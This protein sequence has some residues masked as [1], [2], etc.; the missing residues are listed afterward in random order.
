MLSSKK[1]KSSMD[2]KHILDAIR[3]SSEKDIN[4]YIANNG[5]VDAVIDGLSL[6]HHAVVEGQLQSV[7]TLLAHNADV[8]KKGKNGA[9]PLH[10]AAEKNE[11]SIM[12]VLIKRGAKFNVRDDLGNTPLH[13]AVASNAPD[14][15]R[16]CLQNHAD[17][18]ARNQRNCTPIHTAINYEKSI[19]EDGRFFY[20][21][22]DPEILIAL[23]E[24][25]NVNLNAK[26]Y[27]SGSSKTGRS[28][29]DY[30]AVH[31]N[32]Y[33]AF[34]IVEK[35][36]QSIAPEAD[37]LKKISELELKQSQLQ[38]EVNQLKTQIK[39]SSVTMDKAINTS[40]TM[41]HKSI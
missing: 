5:D 33:V 40:P 3:K 30:A 18:N 6:L 4:E 41:F 15:V 25:K 9:T 16:Y 28:Y 11:G 23:L 22:I 27:N 8:T 19:K 32:S 34:E 31:H 14:A 17:V 2:S 36:M 12:A 38:Q 29:L 26:I 20:K 1:K 13:C 35:T 10:C 37:L 24:D 21:F 39:N 7:E